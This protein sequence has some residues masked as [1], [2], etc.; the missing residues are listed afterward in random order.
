[1]KR[2]YSVGMWVN[3]TTSYRTTVEADSEEEA[4]ELAEAKLE[5]IDHTVK[6]VFTETQDYGTGRCEEL[7]PVTVVTG[8]SDSDD[9]RGGP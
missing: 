7:D 6:E 9:K 1:V 8:T 2:R 3:K 5:C 4:R